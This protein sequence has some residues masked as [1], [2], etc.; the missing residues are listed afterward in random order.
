M[1]DNPGS[2]I[3]IISLHTRVFILLCSLDVFID[4]LLFRY[5]HLS[6]CLTR[7]LDERTPNAIGTLSRIL[8]C[9]CFLAM[10]S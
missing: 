2:I 9:S 7:I 6:D 10:N 3:L 4:I 5:D 1:V 8:F